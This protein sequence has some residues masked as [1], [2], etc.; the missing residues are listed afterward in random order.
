M[1]IGLH[2]AGE[3]NCERG[4]RRP[5]PLVSCIMPTADRRRFVPQAIRRFLGQDYPSRE[6]VV[7]DDG[8]DP[9]ADLIPDDPKIRYIRIAAGRSLGEK[10][11][12]ALPDNRF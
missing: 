3:P 12:L 9:V 11:N 6:L 2:T 1:S 7:L 4:A 10:C 8:A 5:R